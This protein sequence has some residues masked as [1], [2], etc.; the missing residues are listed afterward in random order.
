MGGLATIALPLGLFLV[1]APFWERGAKRRFAFFG[2]GLLATLLGALAGGVSLAL[3]WVVRAQLGISEPTPGVV[4]VVAIAFAFLVVAPVNEALRVA[5]IIGPLRSKHLKRPYDGMRIA[6]GSCTGFMIVE[7]VARTWRTDASWVLLLRLT[8]DAAVHIALAGLW[9]F[10]IARQRRRTIGGPTFSR[11]F[12]AAILLGS[13]ASHLL[14]ARGPVAM[15]GAIPLVLS[16]M[17]VALVAR[18][19]LLRL[20]EAPKKRRLAK[21]LRL[22]APSIEQLEKALLRAPD[23]PVM[24][25]WIVFS[26]FVTLGVLFT[27][28]A[29]SVLVGHRT[30]VD[31]AVVDEAAGLEQSAPPLVL[32]G[33][34][35]LSA[36]PFSG[37]LVARASA[38]R[39]VLEPALGATVA[40][41]GLVVL[42]GLAAP[43]AVVFGLALAPAAFALA[44]TGAWV[45]LER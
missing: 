20:S 27:M 13:F 6:I 15:W 35:V 24:L 12:F 37:Y 39:S 38:A 33:V 3:R 17:G 40:I 7:V 34:G 43:I 42:L 28:V 21:L 18:R 45:G 29:A 16:A 8:L 41:I 14:L 5:A 10:G 26:A 32:L 2:P 19:D 11:T 25:R 9:G 30:G 1:V 31:F 36:F 44:C 4:D 22:N 23:R